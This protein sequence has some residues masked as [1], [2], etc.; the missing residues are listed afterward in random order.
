MSYHSTPSTLLH[1]N[2]R[3]TICEK[4]GALTKKTLKNLFGC[5]GVMMENIHFRSLYLAPQD[6]VDAEAE[7]E[8][9][10]AKIEA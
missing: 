3:G 8:D 9:E 2:W 4:V 5:S 10:E 1:F 6:E 7:N